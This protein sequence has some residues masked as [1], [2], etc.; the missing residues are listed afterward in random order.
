MKIAFDSWVLSSRL[1]HH[2]TYVYA[3]SLIGQFNRIAALRAEIRFCLFTSQQAANDANAIT[4]NSGSGFELI[5][6]RLLA[7]DR[8][9]RLGAGALAAARARADLIFAPTLSMAP[10]GPIPLVCT[11]H[12]VTPVVM[13][14][15]SA[16]VTLWLR[17]LLWSVVKL[18]RG[19]ITDSECS[20]KDLVRIYGLPEDKVSVVYLGY[21]RAVFNCAPPDPARQRALLDRLGIERP[22]LL[23]HGIVQPRKNLKRLIAAYDLMLSRNRN[24]EMDLVLAGPLG[25]DYDEIVT[26]AGAVGGRQGR[27]IL[28]GALDDA[29]LA[30]LIKGA[31]LVVI[32][33]LYEGFCLPM[34]EAMACGAPV[35][36][37]NSSCLPEVSGGV[38]RYFDPL[39]VED[40]TN[41]IEGVLESE[42]ARRELSREG[43][44][45]VGCFSWERCARETLEV[46]ARCGAR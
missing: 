13:P 23:H 7:Y 34:V 24:L 15:F 26:A 46:L 30:T 28:A 41:C 22:Y 45:R 8:L 17:S 16:K 35:V 38:L 21:D 36:A 29:E 33:S 9:W 2:G 3:R 18:S 20:K 11:I 43:P 6:T 12:D 42:T 31:G 27:V 5:P 25:W 39:S 1:R 19:I 44:A 37:A 40:M 32:P 4:T 14:T 10:V